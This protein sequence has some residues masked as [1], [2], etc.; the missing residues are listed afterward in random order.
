M[1]ISIVERLSRGVEAWNIDGSSTDQLDGQSWIAF[2]EEQT[3]LKRGKCSYVSC[4][5]RSE[6]GGHVWMKGHGPCIVPIC[7]GCN[8]P[9]TAYRMQQADGNNSRLR[10]GTTVVHIS[11][12]QDMMTAQRRIV[13]RCCE[14]CKCDISDRPT[15]H[16]VCLDCWRG[17]RSRCCESCKCDISDRP[18]NHTVC[19]DCWRGRQRTTAKR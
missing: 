16:T 7:S 19:L 4:S 9:C 14:S 12:T 3:K 8:S 11:M 1:D 2:W 15:N 18:T 6:H 10:A 5:R 13:V 17:I